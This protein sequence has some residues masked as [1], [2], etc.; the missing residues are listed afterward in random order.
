MIPHYS[1]DMKEAIY[2]YYI[3]KQ[4]WISGKK[5]DEL[6]SII[7]SPDFLL[8]CSVYRTRNCFCHS[9][10]F[11]IISILK[12]ITYNIIASKFLKRENRRSIKTKLAS[13]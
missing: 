9:L 1:F 13:V 6:K 12:P 8:Q 4:R 3:E 2:I 5:T 7:C 10:L 11:S